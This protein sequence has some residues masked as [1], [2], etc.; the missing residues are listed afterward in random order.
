M[1]LD[2]DQ[3]LCIGVVIKGSRFLRLQESHALL[4][5]AGLSRGQVL[6]ITSKIR[7]GNS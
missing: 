2:L 7:H 3:G 4:V 5:Y 1:V 6:E